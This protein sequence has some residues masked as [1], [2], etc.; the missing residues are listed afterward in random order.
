[1]QAIRGRDTVPELAV[2]RELHAR[3]LRYRVGVPIPGMPRR[4]IDIAWS[5]RI[6]VFIDGCFWHGCPQHSSPP[7]AHPE[8]WGPKIE[9][10]RL[11]DAQTQSHLEERGWIVMRFWEHQSVREVADTIEEVVRDRT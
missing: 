2:R 11:R 9:N 7:K 6:A 10:N 4:S 8:Y 1:M 3:G 5:G